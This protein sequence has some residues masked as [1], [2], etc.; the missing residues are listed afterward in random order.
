MY[1]F[2]LTRLRCETVTEQTRSE[3]S[4]GF[5]VCQVVGRCLMEAFDSDSQDTAV[6]TCPQCKKGTSGCEP[7]Q[8][9]GSDEN[10]EMKKVLTELSITHFV[11]HSIVFLWFLLIF[12]ILLFDVFHTLGLL[13]TNNI[14]DTV[15]LVLLPLRMFMESNK[16]FLWPTMKGSSRRLA[17]AANQIVQIY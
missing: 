11:L 13:S 2:I 10:R 17:T 16:I 8:E 4:V 12:W 6:T 9:G 14:K 3:S 1:L 7:R 5:L 15:V